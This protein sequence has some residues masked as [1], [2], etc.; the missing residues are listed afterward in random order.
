MLINNIFLK[1]F[2]IDVTYKYSGIEIGPIDNTNNKIATELT[3]KL[4]L[5]SKAQQKL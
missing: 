2:I 5:I 1:P 4:S 3:T